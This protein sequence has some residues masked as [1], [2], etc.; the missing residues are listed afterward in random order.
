M[1]TADIIVEQDPLAPT[2]AQI[3]ETAIKAA[4]QQTP[5]QRAA[6]N[7][8]LRDWMEEARA[9]GLALYE[10]Q[11]EEDNVEWLIWTTYRDHYPGRM[12]SMTALAEECGCS[13]AKVNKT[14]KK[15]NFRVRMVEW[16]RFTDAG[17][18]EERMQAIQEMNRVQLQQAQ[19][20]RCVIGEAITMLDPATLKP[21]EI[22]NLMKLA[23]QTEHDIITA[24]P[25]KVENQ[26]L[27]ATE[28]QSQSKRTEVNAIGEIL[29][30]MANCGALGSSIVGI[31]KKT[32][33]T[34]ER[35]VVSGG[36]GEG[37]SNE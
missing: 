23:N 25:E 28:A 19:Q 17:M 13:V 1:E 5:S 29:N 4:S 27:S 33:T 24:M 14:A 31:E 26:V 35:L 10:R 6:S 12:P 37:E 2:K 8:L 3:A 30:I 16:S 7:E 22:A 15:W 21:N 11:P 36:N 18:L 9:I 20:L 32:V 34:T